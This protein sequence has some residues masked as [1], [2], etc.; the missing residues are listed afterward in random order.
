MITRFEVRNYKAL[1]DVAIEL[2]PIHV[3]IG[4]NDSGKT[5]ILEAVEALCRT[6]DHE[7]S[8]AF[9]GSWSGR[10][11]VW[12]GGPDD[13]VS[14]AATL[15]TDADS[16]EYAI[17]CRFPPQGRAVVVKSESAR[18]G[19]EIDFQSSNHP[20]SRVCSLHLHNQDSP[21]AVRMS[22]TPVFDALAGAHFYRWD[23][24]MLALPVAPD[25]K[26]RFRVEYNGF[27]L[28]QLLD[29]ILGYD[30]PLFDTLERRFCSVFPSIRSIRLIPMPAYRSPTDQAERIPELSRSEGKG[31]HFQ[32]ARD[33]LTI[34]AA[35]SSDGTLLVL[36]Y[37]AVVHSP[38]PPSV[39][40]L[41]EPENGIHPERLRDV[42]KILRALT[43]EQH[44]TQ[45]LMTTHSPYALDLFEPHEVTL[46]TKQPD[47][48]V[49]VNRLS[50]SA[51]VR[52]QAEVFTLGEIWTGEGDAALSTSGGAKESEP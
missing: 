7:L 16:I 18:I 1:R 28:T 2:T 50:E 5:S 22:A 41:E 10:D 39:I 49:F 12:N 27:G 52:E 21:E 26:R 6:S 14:F 35:Q 19:Q 34:P 43:E 24:R 36:A 48:S 25:S 9:T 45:I 37:L 40:L 17:S 3:L 33:G 20:R 31:I 30:R 42:L 8:A 47:G 11:L 46:C 44:R 29:D 23:P 13:L 4:P 51:K 38:N 32:L 15:V